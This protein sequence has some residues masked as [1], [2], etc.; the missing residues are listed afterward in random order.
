MRSH[1]R[2]DHS[3][4]VE[5]S[6]DAVLAVLEDVRGY[7]AWWPA[8]RVTGG[9]LP[10]GARTADLEV[11]APLGYRLRITLTEQEQEQDER[12]PHQLRAAIA[13]DLEGWCSWRV[14][15]ES[16]GTRVEFAQEVEARARL[17]RV[18][19]P[20]L[21]R[22][23]ARQHGAVMSSAEQGLRTALRG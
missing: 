6:P 3:W 18:A 14:T 17:L 13:G 8:V 7:G 21:H 5:A 12:R 4:H 11:R 22:V 2:F 10:A 9:S 15:P 20:L 19:S 1:Y 23:F 16:A